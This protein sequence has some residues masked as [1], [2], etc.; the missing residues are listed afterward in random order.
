M[1]IGKYF[2][3]ILRLESSFRCHGTYSSFGAMCAASAPG[4]MDTGVAPQ[5]ACLFCQRIMQLECFDSGTSTRSQ[6]NDFCA[7]VTPP[8]M[9]PPMLAPGIK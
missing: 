4:R 2:A 6:A 7:I 1:P 3:N 5:H 8:K 9:P